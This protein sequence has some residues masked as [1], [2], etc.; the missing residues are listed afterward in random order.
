MQ[1]DQYKGVPRATW[2]NEIMQKILKRQHYQQSVAEQIDDYITRNCVKIDGSAVSELKIARERLDVIHK[3]N[4]SLRVK[5]RKLET[6]NKSLLHVVED[7][8]RK[9]AEYEK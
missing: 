4:Q 8:K 5:N 9:L 1:T 3:T 7:L 6:A 2:G